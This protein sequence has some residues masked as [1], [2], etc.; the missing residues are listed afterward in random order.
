M[1][2]RVTISVLLI[3]AGCLVALIPVRQ[4][5]TLSGKPSVI[6][7]RSLS[8]NSIISTDQAARY[9]STDDP[10]VHF[11]DLRSPEEYRKSSI[12]GAQNIPF[13]ELLKKDPSSYL[14]S[15][16][17]RNIFY[18]NGDLEA[19]YAVV[20]AG[21]LGYNNCYSLKGGLYAFV[22]TINDTAF[23]GKTITAR[24]NATLESRMRA[25]NLFRE[26]NS[27]PDSLKAKYL[28]SKKF[29]PKKLDGGCN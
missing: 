13:T 22:G 21:G 26:M 5:R 27:L 18:S 23:C 14:G 16:K 7:E 10:G 25:G 6:L 17:F 29:N 12:P 15:G 24:E 3:I 9:I 20:L 4:T 1:N 11:I 8:E 19:G 2:P 28:E